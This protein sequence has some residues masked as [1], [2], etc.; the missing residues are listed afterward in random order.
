MKLL[1]LANFIVILDE[2]GGKV[3]ERHPHP[4]I[5]CGDRKKAGPPL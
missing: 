1:E 3:I 4:F 5:S 2:G